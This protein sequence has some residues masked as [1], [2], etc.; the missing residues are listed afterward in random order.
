MVNKTTRTAGPVAHGG[1]YAILGIAYLVGLSV[2]AAQTVQKQQPYYESLKQRPVVR[3]LR[4][5]QAYLSSG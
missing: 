5:L 2:L 1:R 4:R 3:L